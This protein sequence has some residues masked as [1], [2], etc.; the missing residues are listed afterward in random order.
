MLDR[1]RSQSNVPFLME[2]II[3]PWRCGMVSWAGIDTDDR[4]KSRR[5]RI[6]FVIEKY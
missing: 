1:V 4:P 6:Y 3:L 2:T 5:Q